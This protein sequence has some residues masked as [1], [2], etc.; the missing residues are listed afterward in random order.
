[1]MSPQNT[2]KSTLLLRWGILISAGLAGLL[3]LRTLAPSVATLFDDSLEFHVV[4]P[5]LGVAHPPGY[6]LYT[7]LGKGWLTLLPI[8]DAA[9]RLNLFSAIWASLTVGGLYALTYKFLSRS[10]LA[11]LAL[12]LFTVSPT[13]WQVATIA[14][15]YT[16]HLFFTTII[17]LL[18]LLILT[19]DAPVDRL[20]L[21]LSL[22]VGL[23]L[24]HHRMTVLLFPGVLYALWAVRQN[25]PRDFKY[26]LQYGVLLVLPLLLYAYIP[27]VGARV[28]SLDG[29]YHNT[30]QG[31][32]NWVLARDYRV[33]LTGNPFHIHRTLKDFVHVFQS[34]LGWTG[35]MLA[36]VGLLAR[37]RWSGKIWTLWVLT[38]GTHLVFVWHYK[39]ADIDVFCLPL[40]LL[41]IPPIAIG[42]E[43]IVHCVSQPLRRLPQRALYRV[44][45]GVVIAGLLVVPLGEA[46]KRSY[47]LW[48]HLDRSDDWDVYDWG[49]DIMS[50][51]LPEGSV[52]VGIL[53]ETTL[54]RYFRDVLGKRPDIR[55]HPADREDERL[56]AIAKHIHQGE[57]VYITRPLTHV[58]EYYA[59]DA[60]GP[61]IR[62]RP[63]Q[64]DDHPTPSHRLHHPFTPA[65]VLAG[66]DVHS[67]ATHR[68]P[69]VRVTLYWDV[70]A[71][72]Q[73]DYKVSARLLA[74]N[75]DVLSAVDDVP[76]HNTYPT[77]Q[78]SPGERVVDVY[79]IPHPKAPTQSVLIILYRAQD[80]S[81]VARITLPL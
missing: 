30:W 14:E 81:E 44:I 10:P 1:M 54:I 21:G 27:F 59:L 42:S 76:V 60:L 75:G 65:I 15:V 41:A 4:I 29:T 40:I 63:K 13:L 46:L 69:V 58:G 2:Q 80:G 78:W 52:I 49:T 79:D 25:L 32:W 45:V 72:P 17:L 3:Y 43:C 71:P 48:P 6:P 73:D 5:I 68:G 35:L 47:T 57:T 61:L 34:N 28:G 50:Q 26:W 37:P 16:L 51:P 56:Q 20:L 67:R 55:V 33:F 18:T 12:T 62:V 64:E 53:G 70:I 8:R 74:P 31:F 22:V 23:S 11:L 19:T 9:W 36:L 7:L 38:L 39:V 24:T 77:R 66:Y